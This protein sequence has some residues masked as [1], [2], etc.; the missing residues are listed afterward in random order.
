MQ[1]HI[2]FQFDVWFAQEER[3]RIPIVLSP[4][5]EPLDAQVRKSISNILK[6]GF[7]IT[8][9][10]NDPKKV[11]LDRCTDSEHFI[12][13]ALYPAWKAICDYFYKSD[14]A[15]IFCFDLPY[16]HS[17]LAFEMVDAMASYQK[18]PQ[19]KFRLVL[20]SAKYTN[21]QMVELLTTDRPLAANKELTVEVT[22]GSAE[23]RTALIHQIDDSALI[24]DATSNSCI[25]QAIRDPAVY[26][27]LT[28]MKIGAPRPWGI[29]KFIVNW[30]ERGFYE[31]AI[32]VTRKIPSGR[33]RMPGVSKGKST[34]TTAS[35]KSFSVYRDIKPK[36][37]GNLTM[38]L[39]P[40]AN[41]S[42]GSL[43]PIEDMDMDDDDG[44]GDPN[45]Y[46]DD[47]YR[48]LSALWLEKKRPVDEIVQ[49]N[50]PEF[51]LELGYS[52]PEEARL[53]L[54]ETL[55]DEKWSDTFE[56]LEDFYDGEH[57]LYNEVDVENRWNEVR[58]RMQ[59]LHRK[60]SG[61]GGLK[62]GRMGGSASRS[63]TFARPQASS[64]SSNSQDLLGPLRWEDPELI[65]GEI[66]GW[67]EPLEKGGVVLGNHFDR[68]FQDLFI[69]LVYV[70]GYRWMSPGFGQIF[71]PTFYCCKHG[72]IT[73]SKNY[74]ASCL[75]RIEREPGLSFTDI[76]RVHYYDFR[77]ASET[78]KH[79]VSTATG[80]GPTA[81][82]SKPSTIG[83]DRSSRARNTWPKASSSVPFR[84]RKSLS[85]PA[86]LQ[87]KTSSV[88]EPDAKVEK[89]L[90][91]FE[92][93]VAAN[94]KA[95]NQKPRR[96]P[97]PEAEQ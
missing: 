88:T 74:L 56:I 41:P 55:L 85:A 63:A 97:D 70:V 32:E 28:R 68:R 37:S 45:N 59:A 20:D 64:A 4:E 75:L 21:D 83:P 18:C 8:D 72:I 82:L 2:S 46:N 58:V 10:D 65:R 61:G 48:F 12:R 1:E 50:C 3:Y 51:E 79:A 76:E 91:S 30:E 89:E 36:P 26:F 11:T 54:M 6:G 57:F 15:T 27:S 23:A 9:D 29:L 31:R 84:R 73:G 93:A 92:A 35:T 90:S 52:L 5:P 94:D 43:S 86:H 71:N 95:A 19:T 38:P 40:S 22:D 24:I 53:E 87:S 39:R 33:A 17:N 67:A 80:S 69:D 34:A 25:L 16:N 44:D 14:T 7:W 77:K 60:R 81:T 96:P 78:T 47:R 13:T 49:E 66:L 62:G 42:T